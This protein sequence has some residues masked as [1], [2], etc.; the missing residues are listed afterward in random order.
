MR[1][2]KPA[3]WPEPR[4]GE[5]W[6]AGVLATYEVSSDL[7]IRRDGRELSKTANGQVL[8]RFN[9]KNKFVVDTKLALASFRPDALPANFYHR[10]MHADHVENR[11]QG[12]AHH[13]SNLQWLEASAHSRKT[14]TE[15][16]ATR[17][18]NAAARSK[19]V[20][21]VSGPSHVGEVFS[22]MKEA[23]R[24]LGVT[25][26]S[27]ASSCKRGCKARGFGFESIGQP[28]LEGEEWRWSETYGMLASSR[29]R[30]V[31]SKGVKTRG[32]RDRGSKYRR[33]SRKASLVHCVV[34][35]AFLGPCPAGCRVLHDDFNPGVVVDGEYRN[36]SSDLRYGT[37]SENMK[38]H[39]ASKKAKLFFEI[40]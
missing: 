26:G 25:H 32:S 14:Q 8:L 18:S 27:I 20:R 28:D 34:A 38:E 36:W 13:I 3:N 29:G 11:F 16:K 40:Q 19:A 24:W 23:A 6:I 4:F 33:V 1:I 12:G 9:N 31:T 5:E 2:W 35:D 37:Q 22:S 21:V 39:H 17:K 7:R 10:K 15:T 30:V